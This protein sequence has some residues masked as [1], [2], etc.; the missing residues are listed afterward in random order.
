MLA[1]ALG[2]LGDRAAI[3]QL[4]RILSEPDHHT[5]AAAA[6]ALGLIGSSEALPALI[7]LLESDADWEPRSAAAGAIGMIGDQTA[8]APLLKAATNQHE[9]HKVRTDAAVGLIRLDHDAEPA[10]L[11]Q[12]LDSPNEDIREWATTWCHWLAY[13]PATSKLIEFVEDQSEKPDIRLRAIYA[14]GQIGGEDAVSSLIARLHDPQE[15]RHWRAYAAGSL[16]DVGTPA[17]IQALITALPNDD[18]YVMCGGA[19]VFGLR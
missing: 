19:A 9:D 16:G 11:V 2:N 5:V 15:S 18:Q 10:V 1:G 12:M 7:R 4:L 13:A 3:P 14:L 17:A 6:Q 8:I